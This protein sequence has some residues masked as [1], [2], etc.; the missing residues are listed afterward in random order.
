MTRYVQNTQGRTQQQQDE[1]SLMAAE[2]YGT[3]NDSHS[4][5]HTGQRL[6]LCSRYVTI[7]RVL[8][9]SLGLRRQAPP[10]IENHNVGH[11]PSLYITWHH[12]HGRS[13]SLRLDDVGLSRKRRRK[14]K[15]T[16]QCDSNRFPFPTFGRK[17]NKYKTTIIIHQRE[18]EEEEEDDRWVWKITPASPLWIYLR[19]YSYGIDVFFSIYKLKNESK[20]KGKDN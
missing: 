17:T 3:G 8:S 14:K 18:E 19:I 7:R 5:T 13:L 15:K 10:T 20:G 11:G 16:I 1:C 4:H 6:D 2:E 9:G 12:F